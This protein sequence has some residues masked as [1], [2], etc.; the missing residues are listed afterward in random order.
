MV[1][2]GGGAGGVTAAVQGGQQ[3]GVTVVSYD[4][5][6]LP[7]G[8]TAYVEGTSAKQSDD[9]QVQM[10]GSEINYTGDFVI[11]AAQATDSNQV[12]WNSLLVQDLKT[13]PK[14][15]NM[16]LVTIINP[17]DDSTPTAVQYAQ[18]VLKAYPNI[19]GIIAPTTIAVAAAAQ[20]IQQEGMCNKYVVT[21]LGDPKQMQS[22]VTSGCFNQFALCAFTPQCHVTIS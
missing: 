10:L 7:A 22:S 8:R 16:H 18:S 2:A 17:P 15:K 3:N 4:S 11:L 19:K 9:N 1:N 5:D 20:V 6:V 21:A 12:L 14:Y 13:N